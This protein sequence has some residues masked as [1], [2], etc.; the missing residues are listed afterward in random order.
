MKKY[1]LDDKSPHAMSNKDSLRLASQKY[2]KRDNYISIIQ[3]MAPQIVYKL[4]CKVRDIKN[5]IR[6]PN[7]IPT[8]IVTE[9]H[10]P[11][12]FENL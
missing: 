8:G 11:R 9:G 4:L 6:P 3:V 7:F 1:L 2:I 5:V 10:Y 12:V